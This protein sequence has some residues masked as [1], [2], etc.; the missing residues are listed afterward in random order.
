MTS[1][2][3]SADFSEPGSPVLAG[4]AENRLRPT[5]VC[6]AQESPQLSAIKALCGEHVRAVLLDQ[7][8]DRERGWISTRKSYRR[9]AR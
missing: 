5:T 3:I 1:I 6:V 4:P 7:S 9:V 2:F 8:F